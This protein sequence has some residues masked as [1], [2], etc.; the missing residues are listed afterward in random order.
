[1]G[2]I[3]VTSSDERTWPLNGKILFLDNWCL[4]FERKLIWQKLN[5]EIYRNNKP[6]IE[7]KI[8][9]T[10]EIRELENKIF[11]HLVRIL[12]SYQKTNHT[13]NFWRIL[14][15]HWLRI[16]LGT[17][18][19]R[20]H[21]L[22]GALKYFNV[23]GATFINL[24]NHDLIPKDFES[25]CKFSDDPLYGSCLDLRILN[26]IDSK[27][28]D[29]KTVND[30]IEKNIFEKSNPKNE[31]LTKTKKI[32]TKFL[33]KIPH[34]F[35]TNTQAYI[36]STYLP[37]FYEFILQLSFFLTPKNWRMFLD[38]QVKASPDLQLREN[39]T[40]LLK[41]SVNEGVIT[42]LLFR[43]IPICYLEGF[44]DLVKDTMR[45]NLPANPSFIFTSNDFANYELFKMYAA[46]KSSN[47][48]KYFVGQHGNN[49]GTNKL[50]SP[51]VE[52][53]TCN[54]F[55]TWGQNEKDDKKLSGFVFK[56][57]GRKYRKKIRTELLLVQHPLNWTKIDFSS[58][59]TQLYFEAQKRFF[60]LLD[61]NL[62]EN[63]IVRLYG[64]TANSVH[65]EI[66]QYRELNNKLRID[67]GSER[68]QNL[69][70][71]SKLVIFSYDST[72]MLENLSL[73]IPTMAFW[74]FELKHLNAE[75]Q[76][77]YSMLE[78]VGI[79]HF[80]PESI[81]SK[82][83]KVW[84]DLENWWNSTDVQKARTLFCNRY[85]NISEQPIRDL[86]RIIRENI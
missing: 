1:M 52:E 12:N 62:Y 82:V 54:H 70:E 21:S 64:G 61:T 6:T 74:Q 11:G 4:N 56:N 39:L 59:D 84:P 65:S 29:L 40:S 71:K 9:L 32:V 81:A 30:H 83:N 37:R 48:C 19:S 14:I 75:A 22:E 8:E 43:I 67:T 77:F 28:L 2:F 16:Y 18:L 27:E 25:M 44:H 86:R 5:Y 42:D 53:I 33:W 26:S 35:T 38:H 57:A 72:G 69:I 23:T 46:L 47:N 80:T 20:K 51:T 66:S 45:S 50:V 7:Y 41:E 68:I 60:E 63:L 58:H 85:A 49:Y 73:N 17:T 31:K 24:P 3:L 36:G 76:E 34:L 79:V 10:A 15:G 13:E 55:I 78:K